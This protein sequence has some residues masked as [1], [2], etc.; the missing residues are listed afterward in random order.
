MASGGSPDTTAAPTPSST[1]CDHQL[2]RCAFSQAPVYQRHVG[3]VRRQHRLGLL[4]R[5][6]DENLGR[7]ERQQ[8]GFEVE[9]DDRMVFEHQGSPRTFVEWPNWSHESTFGWISGR[10]PETQARRTMN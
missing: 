7:A 5:R 6:G 4:G 2:A 10:T 3:P 8:T 1:S 9:G